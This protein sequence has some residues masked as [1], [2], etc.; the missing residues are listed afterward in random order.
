MVSKKPVITYS[1]FT[2]LNPTGMNFSII[3]Y[4]L[5]DVLVSLHTFFQMTLNREAG[6]PKSDSKKAADTIIAGVKKFGI[7]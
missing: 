4:N 2:I 6:I 1:S 5:P 7:W 3:F